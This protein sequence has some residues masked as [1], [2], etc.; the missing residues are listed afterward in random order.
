MSS[1]YLTATGFFKQNFKHY[2]RLRQSPEQM[3]CFFMTVQKRFP[4]P[5]E[6]SRYISDKKRNRVY[7]PGKFYCS[8]ICTKPFLFFN[9]FFFG[10]KRKSSL[11]NH[12]LTHLINNPYTKIISVLTRTKN[13]IKEKN[14]HPVEEKQLK[15][16]EFSAR[17]SLNK[18]DI[19]IAHDKMN[20]NIIN[21]LILC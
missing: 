6:F 18:I 15:R 17:I 7:F 14:Y 10:T 3:H 21:Y 1:S 2:M 9:K 11:L 19:L 8:S 5:L 13:Q 12:L 4:D 16:L 20:M